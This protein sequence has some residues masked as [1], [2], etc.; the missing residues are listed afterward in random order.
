MTQSLEQLVS[1]KF[2]L[3]KH[4]DHDEW[5]FMHQLHNKKNE[6]LSIYKTG[7]LY[8]ECFVKSS[9]ECLFQNG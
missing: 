8:H 9:R 7:I 5:R 2:K 3:K 6:H 1:L 4:Q